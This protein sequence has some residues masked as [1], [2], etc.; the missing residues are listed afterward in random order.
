MHLAFLMQNE[1]NSGWSRLGNTSVHALVARW[2]MPDGEWQMA[3]RECQGA[4]GGCRADDKCGVSSGGCGGGKR[5]EQMAQDY[6]GVPA[7]EEQRSKKAPNKANLASTDTSVSQEVES[8]STGPAGRKQSQSSERETREEPALRDGRPAGQP[9]R[10]SG[11]W[12]GR[13]ASG[14]RRVVSGQ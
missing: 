7:D 4:D 14:G 9:A 1:P 13:V 8:G 6:P 10:Q 5:S 11:Q 3:D 2:Q 12:L